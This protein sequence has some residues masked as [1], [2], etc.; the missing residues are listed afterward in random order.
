MSRIMDIADITCMITSRDYKERFIG[1]YAELSIR[2][3]RLGSMISRYQAGT[4][5][6]EP[7]CPLELLIGQAE[8]MGEYKAILEK[9][10]IL[11]NIDLDI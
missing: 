9:R 6:F 11:E 4:L 1:E 10:A 2:L 3:E 8:A 5:D 7:D